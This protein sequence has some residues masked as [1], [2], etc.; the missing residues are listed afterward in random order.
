MKLATVTP[1]ARRLLALTH[2][3]EHFVAVRIHMRPLVCGFDE[4]DEVQGPSVK[5]LGVDRL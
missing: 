5:W 1:V 2:L 3:V 4:T